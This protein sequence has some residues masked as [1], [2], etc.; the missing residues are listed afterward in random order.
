MMSMKI[1]SHYFLYTCINT[2]HVHAQYYFHSDVL[3]IKTHVRCNIL[4][5]TVVP[6]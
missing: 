3:S 5:H 6:V 2:R 1:Y 4:S